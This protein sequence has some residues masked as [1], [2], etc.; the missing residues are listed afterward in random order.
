M[1]TM[2]LHSQLDLARKRRL[3][4]EKGIDMSYNTLKADPNVAIKAEAAPPRQPAPVYKTK[5]YHRIR[6]ANDG[7]YAMVNMDSAGVPRLISTHSFNRQPLSMALVAAAIDDWME[8]RREDDS[9][10]AGIQAAEG[11]LAR[12]RELDAAKVFDPKHPIWIG[13]SEG[14]IPVYADRYQRNGCVTLIDRYRHIGLPSQPDGLDSVQPSGD[15]SDMVGLIRSKVEDFRKCGFLYGRLFAMVSPQSW[16]ALYLHVTSMDS[17]YKPIPEKNA[18]PKP[19]QRPAFAVGDQV[20]LRLSPVEEQ[21]LAIRERVSNAWRCDG[22]GS[23]GTMLPGPM[24]LHDQRDSYRKV[25]P[26]PLKYPLAPRL[27][28]HGPK[29]YCQGEELP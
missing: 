29:V 27:L 15:G 8:R 23:D 2:D 26:I 7:S 20:M 6:V 1:T 11:A 28:D 5:E 16:K 19:V 9:V 22:I 21:R 3:E 14:M 13:T 12:N 17:G 4:I 18:A 25:D 10:K 24:W